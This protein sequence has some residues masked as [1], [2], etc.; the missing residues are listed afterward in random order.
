MPGSDRNRHVCAVCNYSSRRLADYERHMKVHLSSEDRD[1]ISFHCPHC[2]HK[3]FQKSNMETHINTHFPDR[4]KMCP[5]EE[6]GCDFATNDRGSLT[7]HKKRKHGYQPLP[8]NFS[9]SAPHKAGSLSPLSASEMPTS[10]HPVALQSTSRLSPDP[11]A[12]PL[13]SPVSSHVYH[14]PE[15]ELYTTRVLTVSPSA[16][17]QATAADATSSTGPRLPGVR[18]VFPHLDFNSADSRRDIMP[19]DNSTPISVSAPRST[20]ASPR[21]RRRHY[22]SSHI[23]ES[24]RHGHRD[25]YHES[26]IVASDTQETPFPPS[27]SNI[28]NADSRSA[29]RAVRSQ[30]AI[31]VSILLNRGTEHHLTSRSGEETRR[32]ASTPPSSSASEGSSWSTFSEDA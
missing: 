28:L 30:A 24:S 26:N 31:P 13:S 32:A 3:A 6:E 16:L 19:S 10:S 9:N 20:S 2:D 22:H 15:G 11:D 21:P 14:R 18:E 27:T 8:R 7:R 25:G 23:M 1:K 29:D 17:H 4:Q 5:C 12:T